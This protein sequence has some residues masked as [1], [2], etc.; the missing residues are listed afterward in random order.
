MN[1]APMRRPHNAFWR[2]QNDPVGASFP[3]VRMLPPLPAISG[4]LFIPTQIVALDCEMVGVGPDGKRSCV[5]R[6][7]IVNLHG[8]CVLDEYIKPTERV[9][10]WR[11]HVAGHDLKPIPVVQNVVKTM[12]QDRILVGYKVQADLEGLGISHPDTHIRDVA[13]CKWLCPYFPRPLRVLIQDS[14]PR[15][16]SAVFLNSKSDS[17]LEA[18]AVMDLYL[19]TPQWERSISEEQRRAI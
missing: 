4:P 7:S 6:C 9:T 19:S 13:L 18:R 11:T 16:R 12:L 14:L 17:I 3:Y 10:D 1:V 15:E 2:G 8:E 5:V